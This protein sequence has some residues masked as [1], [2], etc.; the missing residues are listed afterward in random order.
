MEGSLVCRVY[1]YHFS[2]SPAC[3]IDER[4]IL[5]S[6]NTEI[7]LVT[8]TGAHLRNLSCPSLRPSDVPYRNLGSPP[9]LYLNGD[10]S[11]SDA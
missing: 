1:I 3:S 7:G 8:C 5:S 2:L 4:S 11:K 9:N 6:F 10:V